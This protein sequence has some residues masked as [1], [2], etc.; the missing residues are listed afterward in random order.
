MVIDVKNLL[1]TYDLKSVVKKGSTYQ[2]RGFI[3]PKSITYCSS[4]F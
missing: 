1:T 2:T 4:N 3:I